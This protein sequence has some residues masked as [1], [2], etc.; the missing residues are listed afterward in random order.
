MAAGP[1][2]EIREVALGPRGDRVPCARTRPTWWSSTCRWA[3]WAGM[4]V[5]LELRLQESYGDLPHIAG[6]DAPRPPA[7][8]APGPALRRRGLAG[9]AARPAPAAP[10]HPARSST[11]AST[12]T[13]PT[14][15]SRSWSTPAPDSLEPAPQRAADVTGPA[16]HPPPEDDHRRAGRGRAGA[17]STPRAPSARG[18]QRH[19]PAATEQER[20]I[21]ERLADLRDMEVREVMT[22]AGRRRRAH[23]PGHAPR[24]SSTRCASRGTAASRCRRRPRRPGR[25]SSS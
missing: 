7:R 4:A 13:T 18:R 14:N 11:A 10:G 25:A 21:I 2:I 9:Q 1:D 6:A 19:S 17:T 12:S 20:L 16:A 5:C 15:R 23:H 8:R 24:T 3:T 22:P